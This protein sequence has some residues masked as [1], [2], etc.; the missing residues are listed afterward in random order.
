MT[1]P[2]APLIELRAATKR[3]PKNGGGIH[4]AIRDVTLSIAPGEFVAVVGPT[5]CGKST[6]LSLI[7]GLAPASEGETFVRGQRVT[8]IPNGIGYMFQADATLPWK[9]VLDNVA[10][11]PEYRG[12][13]KSAARA[14]AREW[15][16]RVGLGKFES[17][18]PHQLSGG[19]RKRVALAQTLVNEPEIMLMDEPFSALDV[20][21]RQLMQ[22]ELLRLWGESDA[23]VVFVTHDL[24][25]AIA[26]ADRVV[27]MTASPATIK[28]DFRV[29]LPRPRNVE[30]VR[31]TEDF[32]D[33]YRRVWESLREEVE[34]ARAAAGN[35][36]PARGEK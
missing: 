15:V 34:L 17:Y 10:S 6:T 16:E 7:S 3:F 28:A 2:A 14:Q 31:L 18:Y 27:V 19:M 36:V 21:T 4:T 22:Q 29:D 9:T 5:G 26:L 11:G 33:L 8:G 25:E 32:L 23:A 12:A 35:P 30:E 24:E 1:A 20:Q 13:P